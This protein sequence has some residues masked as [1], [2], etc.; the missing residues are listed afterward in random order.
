MPMPPLGL[1]DE[2]GLALMYQVGHQ[3][4]AD[5][6][7]DAPHNPSTPVLEAM[8][9]GHDRAGKRH[10]AGFY[11]YSDSGK[12]LWSG[13]AEL[14]PHA[15]QPEVSDLVERFLFAQALEAARCMDQGI[16]LAAADADVGAVMGWGFAPYTGGPLSYID[17]IG[18]P[19]FV[20]RADAL[21]GRHGERFTPPPLLREMAKNGRRFY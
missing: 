2:V 12:R 5:L 11:D 10:G 8:V 21:A 3:T 13:L 9:N 19:A 6:G 16:L 14:Y 20:E 15:E 18:I 17:T 4:R 1:A 7:D